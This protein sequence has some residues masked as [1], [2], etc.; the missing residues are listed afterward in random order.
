[1][2][3]Y[4]RLFVYAQNL[5]SYLQSLGVDTDVVQRIVSLPKD[6]AQ[7]Y[8]NQLRQNP[9]AD[10]G[11]LSQ[12][13]NIPAKQIDPY[14]PE[15]KAMAMRL[16]P[17]A[18]A[19]ALSNLRKG[20]QGRLD[21]S[22][23][24]LSSLAWQS[25][26]NYPFSAYRRDLEHLD[27][28]IR[29][30]GLQDWLQFNPQASQQLANMTIEDANEMVYEWH[31]VMEGKG[32][33]KM[34]EPTKQELI[35]YGPN[36]SDPDWQEWTVQEVRSK[37][38]LLA[39]GNKMSHCV[40]SY[41]NNVEDGDVRIFSLR[42]PSNEPVVTMEANPDV[43][44]FGQ[45]FGHSNSEP[46]D[47]Y[48]PMIKEWIESLGHPVYINSDT[49]YD[50]LAAANDLDDMNSVLKQMGSINEYGMVDNTYHDYEDMVTLFFNQHDRENRRDNEYNGD[51]TNTPELLV[52]LAVRD[53]ELW[54]NDPQI[55]KAH[56]I[57]P[58]QQ[59]ETDL[60]KRS[61][62]AWSDMMDWWHFEYWE[63]QPQPGDFETVEEHETALQAYE[64][65]KEEAEQE[66]MAEI[67]RRSMPSGFLIDAFV[68]ISKLREQGVIPPWS[69]PS[70]KTEPAVAA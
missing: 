2:N 31:A 13:V 66:E 37:N 40:G 28:L 36:W 63:P 50:M 52:N 22:F 39:E 45:I 21:Y 46:D 5:Q 42:D 14:F 51:I 15:E 33:G 25:E 44:A 6:Q 16:P 30:N 59:L 68:Y 29:T 10:W 64:K 56:K 34:F 18:Q 57:S 48:K 69:D 35:V 24:Q 49:Y 19:W 4:R 9:Q 41:C 7:W 47:E 23:A 43:S 32:E 26:N 62:G 8:V 67:E 58:L 61:E 54:E 70:E 38:D 60:Q 20:R 27:R 17:A 12:N 65:Q 1:V 3:W 53:Q 11:Q 55:Q